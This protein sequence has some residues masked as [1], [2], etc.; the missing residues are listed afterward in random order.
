[1]KHRLLTSA[2]VLTALLLTAVPASAAAAFSPVRAY[3]GQFVDVPAREWYYDNVK[4]LYELGLTSGQDDTHFA[5]QSS[6]TAAEAIAM[7]ARLRSLHD[8]ADAEAGPAQ[9]DAGGEWY[10]PYTAYLQALS[11]VDGDFVQD[12]ERNIT[13]AELAHVLARTLPESIFQE[14]DHRRRAVND[15]ILTVSLANLRY[16]PDLREDTPY[17]EDILWLYRWGIAAGSDEWGSFLPDQPVSRSEAA[18]LVT[19]LVYGELRRDLPWSREDAYSA[20]H[21][22][23][24][25]LV[26]SDGAFY[27]APS[28]GDRAQIEAD[29]EWMLSR[30]GRRISLRYPPNT[31]NQAGVTKLLDAFLSAARLHVEQTYNSAQCSF[32]PATGNLVMDFSSSLYGADKLDY[33]RTATMEAAAQV[34]DEMWRSGAITPETSDYDIARLYYTWICEHCRFDYNCGDGSMSHSGW[35][36]FYE[37]LAVCDGYTAAYNLLLKLEGIDCAT[38]ATPGHIWTTA[39]LDGVLWHIDVTWADQSYGMESRYFCMTP[40]FALSRSDL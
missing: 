16:L 26:R 23:M 39:T 20:Q 25:H 24:G 2:M 6:M 4:A 10:S 28:A 38:A 27:T 29:V 19:R 11:V 14:E 17:L 1:M 12:P 36:V 32:T 9:Y 8:R 37:G 7:A 22:T 13:R 21:L 18:A 34:H 5:P 30:G 40:D 3:E 31:L 15:Q 33:Y 35:R